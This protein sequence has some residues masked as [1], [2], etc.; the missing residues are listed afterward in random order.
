MADSDPIKELSLEKYALELDT[1]GLTIVPPEVTGVDSALFDRC[2]EVLLE[3]FSEI[4][5]GCGITLED[6]PTDEL[7]WPTPPK[8]ALR[9]KDAPEPTQMLIQQL[10][11]LDR[12]FRD[13][14]VNPVT[15]ALIGHLFGRGPDGRRSWRYSSTNSFV[16]WQ[17][18]FGYGEHLGL[19]CDQGANPLPW[20]HT[21]LTANAT[22]A[23]T[24]YTK[25]DGALAYV[26]KSHKSNAH[27]NHPFA[28]GRAVAAECVPG[29]V[30]IW[31]GATWHGAYPKKT[32]G[33]RLN[34]VA[35]YRHHAVLPQEN[36]KVTM[37]EQPWED[38]DD[39][40][41]MRELIGFDDPFPYEQQ[42]QPVPQLAS[43]A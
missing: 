6:G 8:S 27:P 9:P 31:P 29:S 24:T 39:P 7:H 22:W 19:H 3:K 37:R 25:E 36:M 15:D 28:A 5:G 18:D 11:Q 34:A 17:G 10:L 21:S 41:A 38:C 26:P 20:G 40:K 32:K 23:L 14:F 35:Y 43:A 13:L 30:I 1:E 33:L 4:T 42:N 2:T 12:C 16:K